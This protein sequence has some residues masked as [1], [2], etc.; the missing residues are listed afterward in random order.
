MSTIAPEQAPGG[1]TFTLSSAAT[2]TGVSKRTLLRK[3]DQLAEHGATQAEDG[4]WSI[5]L[6]AL[7]A[8]GANPGKPRTGDTTDPAPGRAPVENEERTES[9]GARTTPDVDQI[10]EFRVR[11]EVAEARLEAQ[12]RVLA[13]RDRVIASLEQAQRQLVA[14]K[15]DGELEAR[16]DA[17]QVSVREL[18][19]RNENTTTAPAWLVPLLLVVAMVFCTALLIVFLR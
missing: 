8:I 17:L 12:G 16:L 6:K 5:P 3:I 9:T 2:A 10:V 4:T 13:E 18:A 15:P 14:A 11:A 1:A 7:F 19:T